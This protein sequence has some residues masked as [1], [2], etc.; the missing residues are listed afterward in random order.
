MTGSRK[1]Q[2][3]LAWLRYIF[4]ELNVPFMLVLIGIQV[5]LVLGI[6]TI[7]YEA[8]S[9]GWEREKLV[10]SQ[11]ALD[12]ISFSIDVPAELDYSADA[13][14]AGWQEDI[15]EVSPAFYIEVTNATLPSSEKQ[16]VSG[17]IS[18]HETNLVVVEARCEPRE[19]I[20]TTKRDDDV[21]LDTYLFKT[22]EAATGENDGVEHRPTLRCQVHF[23]R[24]IGFALGD[25]DGAV[26]YFKSI[27]GSLEF[28]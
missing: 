19:C 24:E 27:C 12:D 20:V 23:E 8:I 22:R 16:A 7:I 28:I 2:G 11:G 5:F 25:L 4:V 6:G 26:D 17:L 13:Y 1:P 15:G 3:L 18:R 9:D 14:S 21:Q 10:T